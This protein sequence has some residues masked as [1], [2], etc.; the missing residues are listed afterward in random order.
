MHRIRGLLAE[1]P[2][3]YRSCEAALARR[4]QPLTSERV[5][6]SRAP[7]L[8]IN[9]HAMA[10]RTELLEVVAAWSA[11]VADEFRQPRPRSRTIEELSLFLTRRLPLL[12]AHPAADDFTSE[13]YTV[14]RNARRV[15]HGDTGRHRTVGRCTHAGCESEVTVRMSVGD[16]APQHVRC[17]AGHTWPPQQWLHLV[18]QLRATQLRATQLRAT[19]LRA[20]Q[21]RASNAARHGSGRNQARSG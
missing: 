2:H 13:L 5:S 21:L 10:A 1:L 14:A 11:L 15:A 12:L 3:V 17:E 16:P 20:T 7:S 18:S 19:Q 4:P 9:E 8:P 6:G